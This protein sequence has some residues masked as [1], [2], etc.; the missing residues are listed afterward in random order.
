MAQDT[1]AQV[2]RIIKNIHLQTRELE[3]ILPHVRGAYKQVAMHETLRTV[4]E[5]LV[6]LS[7]A[8]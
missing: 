7:K 8:G 4:R 1:G 6:H 2:R 3:R 5:G